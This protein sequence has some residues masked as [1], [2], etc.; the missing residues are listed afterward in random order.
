MA[1]ELRYR[2]SRLAVL[3]SAVLAIACLAFLP[4]RTWALPVL[5]G[6]SVL[7]VY[8]IGLPG[9]AATVVGVAIGVVAAW[10]GMRVTGQQAGAS[11]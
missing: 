7:V 1:N 5:I 10:L 11:Q 2:V 8:L 9:N 4:F 6:L 3:D